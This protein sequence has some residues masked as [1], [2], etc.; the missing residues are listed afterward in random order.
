ME[1]GGK[2]HLMQEMARRKG[3]CQGAKSATVS[4]TSVERIQN[5]VTL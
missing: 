4:G 5:G 2:G 1:D 3:D